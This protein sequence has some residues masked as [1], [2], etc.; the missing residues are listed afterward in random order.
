MVGGPC[1]GTSRTRCATW[2]RRA[3]R[4]RRT[5]AA[6]RPTARSTRRASRS[7][8]PGRSR[9]SWRRRWA[10]RS[11][12]RST[13]ARDVGRAP[14]P[15]RDAMVARAALD[16]VR[17]RVGEDV[18]IDAAAS[19]WE[20]V[21][22]ACGAF[23]DGPARRDAAATAALDAA[24][25][26]L[27]ALRALL[28]TTGRPD[29]S[30]AAWTYGLRSLHR[31]ALAAPDDDERVHAARAK[32][33]R[34]RLAVRAYRAA[35][36]E[37]PRPWVAEVEAV[38]TLLGDDHDQV[39]VREQLAAGMGGVPEEALEHLAQRRGASG[40]HSATRRWRAWRGSRRSLRRGSR[41]A[42]ARTWRSTEAPRGAGRCGAI[43][44]RPVLAFGDQR[45]DRSIRRRCPARSRPEGVLHATRSSDDDRAPARPLGRPARPR[46]RGADRRDLRD[47]GREPGLRGA[48]R[49]GRRSGRRARGGR[50]RVRGSAGRE[51]DRADVLGLVRR[52]VRLRV[53]VPRHP[54]HVL[55]RPPRVVLQG[56]RAEPR[57]LVDRRGAQADVGGGR[58]ALRGA[59]DDGPELAGVRLPVAVR[60]RRAPAR[61]IAR[62]CGATRRARR[63]PE[64]DREPS[65]RAAGEGPP[66]TSAPTSGRP[67]PC[68]CS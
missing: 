46:L 7:S 14:V 24:S 38:C 66:A 13:R 16:A 11:P 15:L 64:R 5:R 18:G 52:R 25:A 29:P 47:R 63:P 60:R 35:A 40:R 19:A 21:A 57:G 50:A 30:A 6:R 55:A 23:E 43:R 53:L 32:W 37:L 61:S 33:K 54:W 3:C 12:A 58:R 49:C 42:I 62:P 17:A 1:V 10:N 8:A 67:P 20:A 39:L 56:R 9:G 22:H 48:N 59:R 28:R 44:Q 26:D 45:R 68:C 34:L 41:R 51:P 4:S 65:D 31:A 2:R 27:E 36:P